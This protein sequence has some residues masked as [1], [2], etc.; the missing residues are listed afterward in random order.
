MTRRLLRDEAYDAL[1]AAIVSGDL[2]PGAILSEGDLADW[3]GVSRAPVRAAL[4]RLVDDGLVETKP[5]SFTRVTPVLD[6]EVRDAVA[7]VRAMHELAVRL[8]APRLTADDLAEMAEA[9][10][11]FTAAVGAGDVEAALVADDAF[12]DVPVRVAGN[13]PA[14]ATIERFTP[15]IRRLERARFGELPGRESVRQHRLL[16]RAFR[17]GDVESAVAVTTTIWTAL[18][19]QLVPAP[20][21]PH[22]HPQG[23]AR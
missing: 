21:H 4:A 19:R 8:A 5:Q 22:P 3:L 12:H 7:V 1:R 14:T 17:A 10:K 2:E 9:N 23:A 15:L 6:R 20:R 11:E 13:R 16:M 18:E